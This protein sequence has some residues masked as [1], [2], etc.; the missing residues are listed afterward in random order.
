MDCVDCPPPPPPSFSISTCRIWNT[1]CGACRNLG[2]W[3]IIDKR[4]E[5]RYQGLSGN[6]VII[7]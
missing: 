5:I 4:K 6:S 2:L 7:M 1:T 3:I